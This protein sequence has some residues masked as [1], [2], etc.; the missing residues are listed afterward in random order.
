M[1]T[2][3]VRI[4]WRPYVNVSTTTAS[5]LWNSIYSVYNA[6]AVGSSSLKT[7]LFAAYNG[8]SNA[9]DSKGTNNGTA[10]GGLTYTAGKIGNAF[11]FNGSNAYVTWPDDSM[12]LTGD[13]T[14]S[15]W[16][17]PVSGAAQNLLN[18]RGYTAGTINKGF[19]LGI[20]NVT[21]GQTSK[22]TWLQAIGPAS[23]QYTGWE[24]RTTSLT[25]NAW[26]HV[27]ITRVSGV[28]TYCWV[29]NTLQTLVSTS[30]TGANVA[31]DPTYHTTQKNS[32]GAF[33]TLA[34]V[35]SNFTPSGTKVDGLNIWNKQL[36]ADERTELYNSGNG[37]QYIT[38]SFY[39]PTTNDALNTYN[40]TAQGG[41][42]YGVGKVGTAFQ[43][44]GTNAH[45]TIPDGSFNL[46]SDFSISFWYYH[47]AT[48]AQRILYNTALQTTPTNIGKGW[49]VNMGTIGA[50][51]TINF[52]ISKG[53]TSTYTVWE[54][55]TTTMTLNTWHH[56]V[57][58]RQASTNTFCW[59][60][61]V[62]Q[63]YTLRGSG[64]D[65]TYDPTYHTTQPVTI[66]CYRFLNGTTGEFMK[67]GSK[68]D[69]FNVW[70]RQLTSTEI[71][72][73][74]NSGN[75]KQYPN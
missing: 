69:A 74:Y 3:S 41:L 21:G 11:T 45:A 70:N 23:N 50:S 46:T 48:G 1:A 12:N 67:S 7:S 17:Y 56:V 47:A 18:N 49:Q 15:L 75:G 72:E 8:E 20:N 24:F 54:F 36:T 14:I 9:N 61:G 66:G 52:V 5:T 71:A 73:L 4:G 29:N 51:N 25:L 28:N 35:A 59:I 63:A 64:I 6:D 30:G 39:K 26:N 40:G 13:F 19:S 10:V 58:N 43:F 37:A 57:I 55:T 34:G 31:L 65:I 22:V 53:T 33:L 2:Q 16:V 38:D 27:V 62:S 44:N 60:N 68:L 32:L 42:T